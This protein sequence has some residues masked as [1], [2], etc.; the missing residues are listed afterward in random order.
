M[1]DKA[2]NV[3]KSQCPN[4]YEWLKK[5]SRYGKVEDFILPDYKKGIR[6]YLFTKEY[7]YSISIRTPMTKNKKDNGYLGCTVQS[8]K[9]RAGEDWIR[10]ND[11]ADGVFSEKTFDKIKND[12]IAYELVKIVKKPNSIPD[13]P[14]EVREKEIN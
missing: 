8:R 7:R 3:I 2:F 5:I 1:K 4:I 10:G 14:I 11:L 12:I 9:P 13:T 6:V